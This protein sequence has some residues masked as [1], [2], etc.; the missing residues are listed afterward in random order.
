MLYK[1]TAQD[2]ATLDEY[3]LRAWIGWIRR[4]GFDPKKKPFPKVSYIDFLLSHSW[5][6]RPAQELED[7]FFAN[8]LSLNQDE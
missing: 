2:V 1:L 6:E 8:H 7:E 3:A 5:R 4:H